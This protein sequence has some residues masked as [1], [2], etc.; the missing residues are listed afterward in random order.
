MMH[1]LLVWYAQISE[2]TKSNPILAGAV[3][4]WGLGVLT[5]LCRNVP[6]KI[7]RFIYSQCTTSLVMNNTGYWGNREIFQGFM[8]W[9]SATPYVKWSRHFSLEKR[10]DGEATNGTIVVGP[11]YGTHF[12]FHKG[13]VFWFRKQKLD[14][15]GTNEQKEE[16]LFTMPG[17][18]QQYIRDL[19]E[20]F[21]PKQ[22]PDCLY[23]YQLGSGQNWMRVAAMTR[24][25]WESVVAPAEVLKSIT[26]QIDDFYT[27]RDWYLSKGLGHKLTMMI[28]G[29]P[30]CGK[31]SLVKALASRYSMDLY[32]ININ[33]MSDTS[34]EI[35]LGSVPK[36]AFLLLEDID[37]S[38]SVK[39]R[40]I[41]FDVPAPINIL[42]A[43]Q[44]SFLSLTGILNALDGAIPLDNIVVFMTTN[45]IEKIDAALLRK[46]RTDHIVELTALHDS[47]IK[48]Y[49]KYSY[50]DNKAFS[51][52]GLEN[53][54]YPAILGCDL[55]ALL[56]EHK[57]NY[58][59]FKYALDCYAQTAM[60]T[61][62]ESVYGDTVPDEVPG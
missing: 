23:A 8:K 39:S 59:E 18:N 4:L 2:A 38:G 33:S 22:D 56:L 6:A 26:D 32:I 44:F 24:R 37:S 51:Q 15:A 5:V 19:I 11:G 43:E 50:G 29:V 49:I 12:L 60:R 42:P 61:K 47:E 1:N 57:Q 25:P 13:H 53:A 46:G 16:I 52:I 48:R 62:V 7:F 9:Y 41:P 54:S 58:I 27:M 36:G 17:R 45:H 14:S 35:A 30:G 40:E 31:T 55:Q 28:H 10:D 34:L 20:S 3:S 21:R